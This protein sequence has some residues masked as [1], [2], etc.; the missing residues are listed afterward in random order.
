MSNENNIPAAE[1]EVDLFNFQFIESAT[2]TNPASKNPNP[3]WFY[4]ELEITLNGRTVTLKLPRIDLTSK[5]NMGEWDSKTQSFVESNAS[6]TLKDTIDDLIANGWDNK[7]LNDAIKFNINLYDKRA[8]PQNQEHVDESTGLTT[9]SL[10]AGLDIT[11]PSRN[12]NQGLSTAAIPTNSVPA[13]PTPQPIPQASAPSPAPQPA[14]P[15]L[16]QPAT[17]P[18][19]LPSLESLQQQLAQQQQMFQ[20]LTQQQQPQLVQQVPQFQQPQTQQHWFDWADPQTGQLHRLTLEQYL[21]ATGQ[22]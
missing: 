22:R 9:R 8:A 12:P 5:F 3:I 20:Q 18:A 4:P 16:P 19:P 15:Q 13:N 2:P 11:K 1:Q 14:V 7:D 6:R 17:A 10:A 21:Q